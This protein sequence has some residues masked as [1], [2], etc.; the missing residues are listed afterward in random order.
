MSLHIVLTTIPT[1]H[2]SHFS[3]VSPI[4]PSRSLQQVPRANHKDLCNRLQLSFLLN[5][6]YFFIISKIDNTYPQSAP[7]NSTCFLNRVSGAFVSEIVKGLH[8][9]R[10]GVL[11]A[12]CNAEPPASHLLGKRLGWDAI[13]RQVYVH[14]PLF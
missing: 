7:K 8:V 11:H 2:F 12:L 4:I 9:T 5:P 6:Q 1:S 13:S 10:Q 14:K 3:A